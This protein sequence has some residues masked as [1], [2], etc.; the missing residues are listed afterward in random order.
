M[1]GTTN[2][3]EKAKIFQTNLDLLAEQTLKTVSY[4]HLTLPPKLEV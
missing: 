3:I 2:N 4:T 1:S